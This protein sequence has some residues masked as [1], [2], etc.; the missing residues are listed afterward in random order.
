MSEPVPEKKPN[1]ILDRLKQKAQAGNRNYLTE[2]HVPQS[3][4]VSAVNCPACGA[5]RGKGTDLRS[6]VQCG[7]D[8][9]KHG[10]SDGVYLKKTGA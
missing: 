10:L 5:G 9:L 1:S 6:C 8:F 4:S 2:G 3:A 7:H